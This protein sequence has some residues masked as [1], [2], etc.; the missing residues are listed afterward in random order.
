[1]RKLLR[2]LVVLEAL[3][4]LAAFNVASTLNSTITLIG[5]T[6]TVVAAIV[7]WIIIGWVWLDED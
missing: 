6:I 1:M 3:L 2:F 5:N 7:A 4:A